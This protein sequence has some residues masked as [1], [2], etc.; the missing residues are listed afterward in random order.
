L[1]F[2]KEFKDVYAN[3]IGG[4]NKIVINHFE[5]RTEGWGSDEDT[6]SVSFTKDL[7][8][9]NLGLINSEFS[10]LFMPYIFKSLNDFEENLKKQY[11]EL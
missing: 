4:L 9:E 11:E 3:R 7:E 2:I 1:D 10:M 5:D 8:A 6:K